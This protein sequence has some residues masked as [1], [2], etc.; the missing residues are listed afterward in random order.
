M[1]GIMRKLQESVTSM[2]SSRGPRARSEGP[3]NL[4]HRGINKLHTIWLQATYPFASCGREL[5]IHYPCELS[6]Q[7]ATCIKF[8]DSVMIRK[9]AWLN[10]VQSED[11][12][13]KIAIDSN[14]VIGAR[15]MISA[16]NFIHVERDVIL[17]ASVLVQDH[18]HAYG[19]IGLPICDQGVTDGGRIR[20][21]QGCWIGYGAVILCNH[22]E[23]VIGR[24][25]VIGAN[26]VVTKS[27]PPYSMV[28]GN[29]GRVVKRFDPRRQEWVLV[30]EISMA[31]ESV[32]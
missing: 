25:T 5:S 16:K 8:G 26:S 1:P 31:V 29:P 6:R 7:A 11:S 3:L 19:D 13:L 27:V 23:L 24:N 14:S 9:D 30:S 28:A 2:Q 17:S 21:E 20:I 18:A 15:N 22:G 12:Q 4:I 32:R 10:V